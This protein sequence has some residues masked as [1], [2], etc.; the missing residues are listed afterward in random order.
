MI[1]QP[2][3]HGTYHKHVLASE[4]RA[5]ASCYLSRRCKIFPRNFDNGAVK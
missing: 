1:L 4:E 5:K 3:E 2:E